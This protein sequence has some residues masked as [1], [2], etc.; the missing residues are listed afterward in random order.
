MQKVR[1]NQGVGYSTIHMPVQ[2]YQCRTICLNTSY[3]H[4]LWKYKI[5]ADQLEATMM[6]V[7]NW[8]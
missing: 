5:F 3:F 4:Y 6:K 1:I 8:S 7:S 2:V